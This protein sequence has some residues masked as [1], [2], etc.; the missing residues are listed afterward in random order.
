[1]GGVIFIIV[2]VSCDVC[3]EEGG[4]EVDV[5][6]KGRERFLSEAKHRATLDR[7]GESQTL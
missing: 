3:S 2:I 4:P 5:W 7:N 6:E 1:M